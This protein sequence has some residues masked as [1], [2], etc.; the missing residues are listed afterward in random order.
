MK[1][2]GISRRDFL[3]LSATGVGAMLIPNVLASPLDHAVQTESEPIPVRPLGKTGLQL[4]ILSMGVMRADNPNVVRA[5]YNSG[6]VHFDTAHGY[7]NGRNEEMLG[8]FFADKPRDSFILGTKVKCNYPCADNYEES[9]NNMFETSLKRLKMDYVDIFYAHDFRSVDNVKDPRVVAAMSALKASGKARFIGFSTH[10]HKPELIHAA[11]E[12]G[13]Y[14]VI[15]CSYNFKLNNIEE[16]AAAFKAAKEAG[17]GIVVMKAMTGGAENPDGSGKV[18][19]EACLKWVWNDPNIT[20]IIPGFSN[21]DEL[22]VCLAAATNPAIGPVEERYLADLRGREMLYCQQCG[23]CT[24]QCPKNLPIPDIMRAYMY[25]YGYK[26]AQLSKETLAEV[27]LSADACS[28]CDTCT[29]QCPSGFNVG[30]KIAAV[31]PVINVPDE[32]LS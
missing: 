9:L 4:P 12:A 11:I 3:R 22:D 8:N 16:T 7:Q 29:V 30:A 10:A 15:L 14:D 18:N 1:K 31:A 23:E 13:I 32:F 6:I 19:A 26:F 25:A 24:G 20:T 17:I 28:G 5:A 21:F 2:N 27:Q